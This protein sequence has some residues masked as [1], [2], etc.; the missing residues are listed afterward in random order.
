TR[1]DATL[2]ALR[3]VGVPGGRGGVAGS[4]CG[5][6]TA[7][8]AYQS[9]AAPSVAVP[10]WAPAALDVM[11]SSNAEPFGVCARRV[12]GTPGLLPGVS[13]PGAGEVTRAA[14]TSSPASTAA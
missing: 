13:E 1:V 12:D 7:H 9:V 3:P 10:C 4:G 14:N 8:T 2:V 11:A 6:K 5:W